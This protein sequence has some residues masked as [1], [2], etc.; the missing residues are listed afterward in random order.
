MAEAPDDPFKDANERIRDAGKWLIAASAAVGAILV[1]GSQL[2]SIGKLQ[3]GPRLWTAMAGAVLGLWGVVAAIWSAVRLLLPVQ[4]TLRDVQTR[5][6][7]WRDDLGRFR[8]W[9]Q[10]IKM[11]DVA[12]FKKN[13][14]F[15]GGVDAPKVLEAAYEE[16]AIAL[17]EAQDA[18]SKQPGRRW[19]RKRDNTPVL[20]KLQ[21]AQD[22]AEANLRIATQYARHHWL[23]GQFRRMLPRLLLYATTTAIGIGLFAWAANPPDPTVRLQGASLIGAS[24]R[25]ADLS[26]A[27]LTGAD[28]TNTDLT[29]ASLSGA[30]LNEVHWQNTICP[31]GNN[32]DKVGGT[33]KGH[34]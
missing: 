30:I 3:T 23:A 12:F 19:R 6:D 27:D 34:L 28:L 20:K 9:R 26:G 17:K 25:D 13:R 5:W 22:R 33:C 24:L 16:A 29:G 21:D 15:L 2:S 31:D 18:P 7:Q 32:S 14:V 11:P 10:R 4:I 8:A 1:A